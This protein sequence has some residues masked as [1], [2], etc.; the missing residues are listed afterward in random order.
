MLRRQGLLGD[1]LSHA[2][3]PGICIAFLLTGGKAPLCC[4]LGAGVAGWLGDRCCCCTSCANRLI[5]DTALGI[6]L[7]VFFGFGIVLLT[8]IPAPQRRQPG[9]AGQV[10]VRPGR[11]AGAQQRGDDGRAGRRGPAGGAALLYKEFKLLSFDPDFAAQPG[12][13]RPRG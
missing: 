10:P 12:L 4:W 1:T 9:G 3:L 7:S 8:F 13:H 6:V 11:G 2:A 5:E